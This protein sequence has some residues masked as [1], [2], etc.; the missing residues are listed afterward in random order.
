LK[1]T[2]LPM[3]L[4]GT[5][6]LGYSCYDGVV[7]TADEFAV[8]PAG[9]QAALLQYAETGG[10]LLILGKAPQLPPT[11]LVRN[12]QKEQIFFYEAGFGR[13][14]V[15]PDPNFDWTPARLAVVAETWTETGVPWQTVA[16]PAEANRL[17]RVVDDVGIPVRSLFLLMVVFSIVIGPA[18]LWLLG[19]KDR[20][21]W[22]LWTVPSISFLTCLAVFGF[23]LIAEGWHGSLRTACITLLDDTTHRATSFGWTACYSPLTPSDGLHFSPDTEVTWQK[24]L[25]MYSYENGNSSCTIDW[26]QDQHLASG[27]VTARVPSHF[28]VRKSEVRRERLGVSRGKEGS[29]LVTN[30]LGA[31]VKELRLVDEKGQVWTAENI[32]V[33]NR[34]AL[35]RHPE[36]PVVKRS[37]SSYR[38]LL[39]TTQWLT[40]S[41]ASPVNPT[42][43]ARPFGA[44]ATMKATRGA[45][46][47][48]PPGMSS[49]EGALGAADPAANAMRFLAPL[50]YIAI[51]DDSVFIEDALRNSKNRRCRSIVIGMLKEPDDAD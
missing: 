48:P 37:K 23:M 30:G 28:K 13:C 29:L 19:R 44:S 34:V 17:F 27:W 51:L 50:T 24:G 4:W 22:L 33:G 2:D 15:C 25:E 36:L 35:T 9:V 1:K 41:E 40:P 7:V 49:P 45:G 46:G 3:L 42:I 43:G 47:M 6:W 18:N 39:K 32:P 16:T 8:A 14:L 26:T 5:S 20:R 10:S 11:W 12:S 21:I 38:D 31:D